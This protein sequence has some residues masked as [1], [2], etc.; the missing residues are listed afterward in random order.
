MVPRRAIT[1]SAARTA[2]ASA[3]YKLSKKWSSRPA[4]RPSA[5]YL[6]RVESDVGMAPTAAVHAYVRR[7]VG[8]MW[9]AR[10]NKP[11]VWP[12]WAA[13]GV[14]VSAGVYEAYHA[15]HNPDGA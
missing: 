12:L 8:Q 13:L 10:W 6:W 3:A 4:A 1:G 11:D 7:T 9:S 2:A 14:G 15:F 5:Y